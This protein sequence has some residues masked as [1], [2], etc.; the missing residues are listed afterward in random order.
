M[1]VVFTALFPFAAFAESRPVSP[2]EFER[3]VTGKTLTYARSGVAYG[4]ERYMDN[5]RVQWSYLNGE[6]TEGY[7]YVVEEQV[8]FIYEDIPGVQCWAFYKDGLDRLLAR[9]ENNPSATE[10]YETQNQDEPL[11]CKSPYLGA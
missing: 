11:Y 5:R 9:F 7:W 1:I 3:L 6:C 2:E 10:L 4:A 8:C